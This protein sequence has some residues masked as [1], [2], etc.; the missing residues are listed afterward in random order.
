M[1]ERIVTIRNGLFTPTVHDRIL[2]EIPAMTCAKNRGKCPIEEN[3][4]LADYRLLP[5]GKEQITDLDENYCINLAKELADARRTWPSDLEYDGRKDLFRC[6]TQGHKMCVAQKLNAAN[7]E[8][9]SVRINL[10]IKI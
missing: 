1:Q 4:V 9:C 7:E 5:D 8:K 10:I 3:P 6:I 2:F